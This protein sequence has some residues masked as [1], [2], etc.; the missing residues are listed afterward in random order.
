MCIYACVCAQSLELC[1]TFC[2]PMDYSPSGF[3][4]Q[5]Y[6]SWLPCPPPGALSNPGMELVSPA[7]NAL[8]VSEF[9]IH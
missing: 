6:W 2:N 1:L 4:R 7:N 9:F 8:K 5:E 3:S